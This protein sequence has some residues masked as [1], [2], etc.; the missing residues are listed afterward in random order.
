MGVVDENSQEAL[1]QVW[2]SNVLSSLIT[3]PSVL[4]SGTCLV[5]VSSKLR[6]SK[7]WLGYQI[8]VP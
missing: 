8:E 2:N 5:R 3:N 6:A 7:L 1:A 4:P